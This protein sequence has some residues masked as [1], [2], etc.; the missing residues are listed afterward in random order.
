MS[1]YD[2]GTLPSNGTPVI[3]NN[4]SLTPTQATDVFE[5]RIGS[6]S[7]INLALTGITNGDD[8]HLAPIRRKPYKPKICAIKLHYFYWLFSLYKG[9]LVSY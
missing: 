4:Y 2:V 8:S 9:L 7:D 5:F 3:R 6:T 1:N